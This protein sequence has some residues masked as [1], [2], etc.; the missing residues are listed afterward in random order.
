VLKGCHASGQ[1]S[2]GVMCRAPW[3]WAWR[4]GGV[5]ALATLDAKP[6][7]QGYHPDLGYPLAEGQGDARG[8]GPQP[9][10]E[11]SLPGVGPLGGL[12]LGA[13]AGRPTTAGATAVIGAIRGAA[14]QIS[15][16]VHTGAAAH[17]ARPDAP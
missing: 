1:P 15:G 17:T 6:R 11:S 7:P 2:L 12:A 10:Q 5:K 4:L 9:L 3:G 8:Q 13:A 16:A 14:T